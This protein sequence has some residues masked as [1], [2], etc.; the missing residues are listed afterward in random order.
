MKPGK[1]TGQPKVNLMRTEPGRGKLVMNQFVLA[2]PLQKSV[3][4][5]S[6]EANNYL[7][8]NIKPLL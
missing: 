1:C 5:L 2:L 8:L 4:L 6:Q 3:Q 7:P